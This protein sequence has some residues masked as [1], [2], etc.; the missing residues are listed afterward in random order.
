MGYRIIPTVEK[1]ISEYEREN[2]TGVPPTPG[3]HFFS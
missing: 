2:V 3:S 1:K